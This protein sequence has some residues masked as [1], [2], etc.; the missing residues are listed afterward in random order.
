MSLTP[1]TMLELGTKAPDFTLKDLKG[2][3][4]SLK[5]F[6]E[7]KALLVVFMC[8][9]CPYVKHVIDGFTA[10]ADEYEK[11]GIGIVGINSNDSETYEDDSPGKMAEFAE[12]HGINFPYLFDES[13]QTALAYKAAC[14]PDFFLFDENRELFYRGQMDEARPGNEV[15]VT[16]KNLRE[17]FDAVLSDKPAPR[18]QKP[19]MG[20]NIKWRE[21]NEP[22]Y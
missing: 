13:Q 4:V 21:G 1:S 12:E 6:S 19:S 18:E 11:K 17:A 10:I 9:H 20:C 15:P 22:V 5:S 14:T 3:S 2:K 16:G 8:N 7:Y